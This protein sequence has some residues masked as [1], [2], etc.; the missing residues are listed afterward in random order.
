MTQLKDVKTG[1]WYTVFTDFPS[2]SLNERHIFQVQGI[3]E[4][5]KPL[6]YTSENICLLTLLP[7]RQNTLKYAQSI[8]Q[9]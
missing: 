4:K 5:Q 9:Y 6:T 7:P 8:E 3:T 1:Q 2:S